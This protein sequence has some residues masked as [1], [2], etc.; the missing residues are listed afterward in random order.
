[1]AIRQLLLRINI[2]IGTKK[3]SRR[4]RLISKSLSS[5]HSFDYL[6]LISRKKTGET[7]LDSY[8]TII[9]FNIAKNK[10]KAFLFVILFFL[11]VI[12]TAWFASSKNFDFFP[13]ACALIFVI[14]SALGQYFYYNKS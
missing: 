7:F 2:I 4:Y 3:D 6:K 1:M 14:I 9:R 13:M 11:N 5:V 12:G 8:E 10:S